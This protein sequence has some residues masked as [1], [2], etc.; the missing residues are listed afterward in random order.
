MI[1]E[2]DGVEVIPHPTKIDEMLRK[3]W[4]PVGALEPEPEPDQETEE[5]SEDGDD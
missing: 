4:L 3:G 1:L 2:K 5:V